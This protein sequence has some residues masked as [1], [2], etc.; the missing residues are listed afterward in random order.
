MSADNNFDFSQWDF[1]VDRIWIRKPN[2]EMAVKIGTFVPV[3][4]FGICGNYIIIRLIILNRSLRTPTNLIIAN[5]AV[6][7]FLTLFICP[8]LFMVN[9]FYQNYQLG[10]VGCKLEGFLVGVFLITAVLN[11][12]VVS[13]DRLTAIVLPT[14]TRLSILGVKIVIPLTW[15]V[16][17]AV[18]SPLAIYRG[19][20]VRQWKNF[21]ET[22][23]KENTTIL[24]KYW[25][26][27]ITVM[28]WFPLMVMVICY[29][30]IFI[31]IHKLLNT[32]TTLSTSE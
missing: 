32:N 4:I 19:Y 5:M 21:K 12:S 30:A 24:P 17:I 18:A 14:E 13:Y 9:D 15:I 3:I 29:T 22:Y 2:W 1:P 16:G 11:L 10:C 6:A 8:A 20:R 23:C 7:D 31:K 28:V 27:L 25:Y 26:F